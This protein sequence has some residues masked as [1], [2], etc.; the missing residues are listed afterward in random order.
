MAIFIIVF[1]FATVIVEISSFSKQVS[2]LL[3]KFEVQLES[4]NAE[5]I[6]SAKN[7]NPD[8]RTA[9]TENPPSIEINKVL[10]AQNL[11]VG[12]NGY[13]CNLKNALCE[14]NSRTSNKRLR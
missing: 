7:G 1:R 13:D 3:T 6:A 8:Q 5:R 14:F 10:E 2:D 4:K 12:K 9:V 11:L